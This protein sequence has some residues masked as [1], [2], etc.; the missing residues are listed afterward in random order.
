M[1]FIFDSE[2]ELGVLAGE[3]VKTS[4]NFH[5]YFPIQNKQI[6]LVSDSRNS[7]ILHT[8]R[9]ATAAFHGA[10]PFDPTSS[11]D[12]MAPSMT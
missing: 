2:F 10:A 4:I 7:L 3:R 6:S 1:A 9:R 12:M 11:N 5:V 8:K